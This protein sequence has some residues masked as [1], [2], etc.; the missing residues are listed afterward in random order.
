MNSR[1]SQGTW[2]F[3]S[4]QLLSTP[5]RIHELCDDL[6]SHFFVM[7]YNA[8]HF[9]E[10]NKPSGLDMK[11]I[12]D[13]SSVS[14][15]TGTHRGGAG[16][17]NMYDEGFHVVFTSQPF[18]VLIRE[19]FKLFGSLKDYNAAKARGYNPIPAVIEDIGKLKDCAAIKTLFAEAL[20]SGGWPTNCD[21]VE[22]Q[23]PPIGH[24]T[25]QQKEAVALSYF[26]CNFTAESSTGKRKRGE[27][28]QTHSQ[29]RRKNKRCKVNNSQ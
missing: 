8:L 17:R 9:V 21:K 25:S 18:T 5:G 16:K 7:L 19:L 14:L 4:T 27:G 29:R 26:D 6:E 1:M 15:G 22:D 24:L 13:Q 23:Y 11:L 3:M 2:Q 28:V 20:K 12:F 10:H